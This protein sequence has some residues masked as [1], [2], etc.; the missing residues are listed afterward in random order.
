MLVGI[1]LAWCRGD[2]L[3]NPSMGIVM[4]YQMMRSVGIFRGVD[5]KASIASG[6]IGIGVGKHGVRG[7]APFRIVVHDAC[8]A[9]NPHLGG[10]VSF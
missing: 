3:S 5:C 6:R 1:A 7:E 10:S 4:A 8:E 9:L 2:R